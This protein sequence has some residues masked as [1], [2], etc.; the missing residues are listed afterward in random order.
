MLHN[1][2][3]L[4]TFLGKKTDYTPIWLMRQAGRYLPEY[5]KIRENAGSFL[6]LCKN[7]D[8]AC[9]VTLQPIERFELDAAIMFS[10]ILVIP[11][12]MGLG[13]YFADGE[14]PKFTHP[15]TTEKDIDNLPEIDIKTELSY[16]LDTIHNIQ[17]ALNSKIPLIGFSGSP[18]TLACYMLEGG[19][20]TTYLKIKH[21]LY[22]NP[23]YLHKLLDKITNAVINYLNE[24]II[25]GVD[26]VMVFDSWG[27]ILS[28]SA[29]QE[30]S[31]QYLQK[32]LNSLIK[33]PNGNAIP[34]IVFT[35]GGGAWLS[36]IKSTKPTA[37]GLDWTTDLSQARKEVGENIVLQGNLDPAILTVGNKEIIWHEV[38][39]ILT[40]YAQINN[41]SLHGHVFNLGHGILPSANIDNVSH[42]IEAVHS[43]SHRINGTF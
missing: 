2:T 38:E 6:N 41:H 16:V 22:Q 18:F 20:S 29:Y 10:D 15:I 36:Q 32:I 25:A 1:N 24:Q 37:I 5:R 14:G 12:A 19:S 7:P 34:T 4:D 3:L 13:L 39:R 17:T 23:K 30:F 33:S 21:W 42:L 28:N 11:D 43:I 35:K 26:V 27:G 40:S 31:L 8:L 9:K